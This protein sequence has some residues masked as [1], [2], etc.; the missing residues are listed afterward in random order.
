[1]PALK[2]TTVRRGGVTAQYWYETIRFVAISAA[3]ELRISFSMSSKGGGRTQVQMEIR[4]DDFP[5]ILEMMTLVDQQAAMEAM[6]EE[7]ARQVGLQRERDARSVT[8]TS[9][10]VEEASKRAREEILRRANSKSLS[11]MLQC[12]D[13]ERERIVRDGV[14]EIISEIENKQV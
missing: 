4:P 11:K 13:D 9:K 2:G 5:T 12:K 1:M 8:E 6:S 10:R 3:S 14:R 7:L